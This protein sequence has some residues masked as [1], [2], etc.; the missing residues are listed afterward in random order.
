MPTI[1]SAS[2]R[3]RGQSDGGLPSRRYPPVVETTKGS[4]VAVSASRAHGLSKDPQRQILLVAGVGVEGDA[5]A[6]PTV[7][8]RSRVAADPSQPNLRQVHLTQ[9]ELHGELAAA[10][11]EVEPGALGENITTRG[12]DLLALPLGTVLGLGYEALVAVT[13]LRNPC[14]QLDEYQAG[15]LKAVAYRDG[16]GTLIRKVGIMAVVLAGGIVSPDMPVT[17]SLPP[18]PHKPLDRV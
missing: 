11:F 7:Q 18:K 14:V 15:L 9:A 8:H 6:G 4:V 3:P 16:D 10:G 12:L 1:R 17:V 13:G 5:H 2:D